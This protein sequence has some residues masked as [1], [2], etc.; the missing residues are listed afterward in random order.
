MKSVVVVKIVRSSGGADD[1]R[2]R[3][4]AV[5]KSPADGNLSTASLLYCVPSGVN[6][7]CSLIGLL[8]VEYID[9]FCGDFAY[10]CQIFKINT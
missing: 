7:D 5:G 4:V 10:V 1:A 9:V 8:T 6:G 2:R 3:R